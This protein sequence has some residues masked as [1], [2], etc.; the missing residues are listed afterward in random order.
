[1]AQDK[2]AQDTSGAGDTT[3]V[4]DLVSRQG[5]QLASVMWLRRCKLV[6]SSP[7]LP[8][9]VAVSLTHVVHDILVAGQEA[10]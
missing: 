8:C 5:A 7:H 6:R 2:V 1:M 9:V 10:V 3:T 4:D